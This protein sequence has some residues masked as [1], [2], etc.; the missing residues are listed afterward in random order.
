MRWGVGAGRV[1]VSIQLIQARTAKAIDLAI[2]VETYG[3]EIR[4]AIYS[5]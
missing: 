2:R 3:D 1:R 4:Q 5:Y